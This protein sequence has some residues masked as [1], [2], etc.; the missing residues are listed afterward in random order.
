VDTPPLS[1]GGQTDEKLRRYDL[2]KFNGR[3]G[4]VFIEEETN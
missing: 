3:R 4:Y 1:F 2:N